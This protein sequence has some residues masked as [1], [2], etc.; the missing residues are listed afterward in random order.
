MGCV[1]LYPKLHVVYLGSVI[2][3]LFL[4]HPDTA[5]TFFG[6]GNVYTVII[7]VCACV[8]VCVRVCAYMCVCVCVCVCVHACMHIQTHNTRMHACM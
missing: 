3:V 4:H 8:P 2:G 6:S 1:K 5:R 7:C